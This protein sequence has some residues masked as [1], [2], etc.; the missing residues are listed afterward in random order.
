[1]LTHLVD[2]GTLAGVDKTGVPNACW[3]SALAGF[4]QVGNLESLIPQPETILADNGGYY[5]VKDTGEHPICLLKD[6]A[7]RPVATW[8]VVHDNER[9]G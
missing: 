1:M 6:D 5:F 2:R 8:N 9:I 3:D 4:P 7:M